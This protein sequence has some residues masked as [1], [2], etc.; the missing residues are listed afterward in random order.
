VLPVFVA[1]VA[2]LPALV[3]LGS[4]ALREGDAELRPA[5]SGLVGAG[6]LGAAA[7]ALHFATP[8]TT[9]VATASWVV[10]V[11]VLVARRRWIFAE[12]RPVD[13]IL[14]LA[15]AA[16]VARLSWPASEITYDTG[17]YHL[18]T[19]RWFREFPL[20]LGIGNLHDRLAYNSVWHAA[21]A[22]LEVPGAVG[23][24]VWFANAIPIVLASSAGLT[25][26]RR[27]AGGD[28]SFPNVLLAGILLLAAAA[29]P[30]VPGLGTDFAAALLAY[31]AIALWARALE[32]TPWPGPDALPATLLASFAAMTKVSTGVVLLASA[33]LLAL[34]RRRLPPGTLRVAALSAALLVPWV[35]RFVAT[36]GCL[37]FPAPAT[38]V[39]FLPWSLT[40]AAQRW[41]H[42]WIR[43]WARRPHV[44][45]EQVLSSFGWIRDWPAL[46][47]TPDH[48]F[49]LQVFAV[50]IVA[51]AAVARERARAFVV[52]AA[53]AGAGAVFWFFTAPA[54][55]FGYGYLYP[56]ALLPAAFAASRLAR[57]APPLVARAAV[58]LLVAAAVGALLVHTRTSAVA[59]T[60]ALPAAAWPART[61]PVADG[62]EVTRSGL[63][64][65]KPASGDQC[66][67]TPLPC[68]P[69]VEAGLAWSDGRFVVRPGPPEVGGG[70][71]ASP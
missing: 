37:L 46:Y 8:I 27:A 6:L 56:L 32:A 31:A 11:V 5:T 47:A 53:I 58:P 44:D 35:A 48:V 14:T 7:S 2:W 17:L 51:C 36:T 61:F 26:L 41:S 67:D 45:A 62:A 57:R 23:K 63:L 1:I 12:A 33:V 66:W 38:C 64:V 71:R 50:G 68:A 55:R 42:D 59:G 69:R 40:P 13:A 30:S 28:T 25:A 70:A 29:L 52:C 24:S 39:S 21:A 20:Q 3:G 15:A 65:R 19:V 49:L 34:G 10:G 43:S 18:Q 9:A 4:V 22:A 54:P 60:P 16:A